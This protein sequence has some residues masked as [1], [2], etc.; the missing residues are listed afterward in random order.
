MR[1]AEV[2]EALA[3][4]PLLDVLLT[5][6][7]AL[8][9]SARAAFKMLVSMIEHD[10]FVGRLVT[11]RVASGSVEVGDRVV[12]C[13]AASSLEYPG[14]RESGRVQSWL[15]GDGG[16]SSLKDKINRMIQQ[17]HVSV[18]LLSCLATVTDTVVR[19]GWRIRLRGRPRSPAPAQDPMG[20]NDSKL[21]LTKGKGFAVHHR[22][23]RVRD[24]AGGGG[25]D[26]RALLVLQQEGGGGD[27]FN[28]GQAEA[29]STSACSRDVRRASSLCRPAGAQSVIS[30]TPLC[31]VNRTASEPLEEVLAEVDEEH[32]GVPRD[33]GV[34]VAQRRAE[35]AWQHGAG[36]GETRLD[37]MEAR[38]GLIG[39][40]SVFIN[41]TRG[42]GTMHVRQRQRYGQFRHAA[43]GEGHAHLAAVGGNR[44]RTRSG[45]WRRAGRCSWARRW[46]CTSCMTIGESSRDE[47]LEVNACKETS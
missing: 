32:V 19:P 38:D 11:G 10:A 39:F 36:E 47:S 37:Q 18:A 21:N 31:A 34:V 23:L 44:R 22:A 3:L 20:V 27:R 8:V 24:S 7:G 43:A 46:R 2:S 29:S 33:R 6:S 41:E 28:L 25:V 35:R 45:S 5:A 40:R 1:G 15:H 12:T 17:G 30:P 42:T 13:L 14:D 26:H 9:G 4:T 16:T